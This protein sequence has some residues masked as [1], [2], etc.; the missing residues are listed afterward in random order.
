MSTVIQG[1]IVFSTPHDTLSTSYYLF[2]E[3]IIYGS[4]VYRPMPNRHSKHMENLSL[5]M[6]I[7]ALSTFC[8]VYPAL[9]CGALGIVFA[10][11]SR[12]GETTFSGRAKLGLTLSSVALGIIVLLLIYSVVF[13]NVYYGGIENMMRES[14]TSLGIDYN[15]LFPQN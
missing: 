15:M 7:I 1:N 4:S 3:R 9:I 12:G 2:S 10:L 6:G 11:L 5:I 14:C 8:L 13:A